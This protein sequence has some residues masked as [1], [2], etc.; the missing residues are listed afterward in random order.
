MT[1]IQQ[2]YSAD[3]SFVSLQSR[4][5]LI[6][7][8][9][10]IDD[11]TVLLGLIVAGKV[12]ADMIAPYLTVPEGDAL[13]DFDLSDT[14]AE[15]VA[16]GHVP[17]KAW[18]ELHQIWYRW[19]VP[20]GAASLYWW[21][22]FCHAMRKTDDTIEASD[23]LAQWIDAIADGDVAQRIDRQRTLIGLD[24]KSGVVGL[25]ND[26]GG[27]SC[28]LVAALRGAPLIPLTTDAD[29][30]VLEQ[31]GITVVWSDL[32]PSGPAIP[33]LHQ[34]VAGHGRRAATLQDL[35]LG[36]P[37]PVGRLRQ[38]A[39]DLW[40]SMPEDE[41]T[42]SLIHL[43]QRLAS[44]EAVRLSYGNQVYDN[45]GIAEVLASCRRVAVTE[46]SVL[47]ITVATITWCWQETGFVVQELNQ[48]EISLAALR[49]FL[50]RRIGDY[51][52]LVGGEVATGLSL[53]VLAEQFAKL[54]RLVEGSYQR[55]LYFDGGNWE[56]R[57]FLIPKIE[58]V[59]SQQGSLPETLRDY[60]R[61]R[62]GVVAD[63]G[64]STEVLK[65][66]LR[67][68]LDQDRTPSELLMAVADWAANT[69]DMWTDYAI[70]TV[71]YGVKLDRPWDI[72]ID[73]Y[74]CYTAIADGFQP[75]QAGIPLKPV[76]ICN[77]IGQRMR[78][79]ALKKAQNYALVKHMT[80]QSFLMP[81]ISVAEDA[82]QGG[83]LAAGVRH[84]CRIPTAITYQ[85]SLWKGIA[86]VRLSRANYEETARFREDELVVAARYGS[87][88][89]AIADEAYAQGCLF[90]PVYC[91]NLEDGRDV[92]SR[93]GK[94]L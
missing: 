83:H 18:D 94:A 57:E 65:C 38:Q 6:T 10:T 61:Q 67:A 21:Y 85:G 19:K 92:A 22:L 48:S 20:F 72:G 36:R 39:L 73:E 90:D 9:S 5:F 13:T 33:P 24:I 35:C 66:Y 12:P 86:D 45:T 52:A 42:Y 58:F 80:P 4:R 29:L 91:V 37:L 41:R 84:T 16:A 68:L 87:W 17:A 59:Q 79:N 64:G 27:L 1:V 89:K 8:E 32:R 34:D 74:F 76:S 75:K 11:L 40:Q 60:L 47:E 2:T 82:T 31:A 62:F 54:R 69:K 46:W 44:L 63:T 25:R 71:P 3:V 26:I 14:M 81:D 55:C 56:R 77:A 23:L 7:P 93:L 30:H 43:Q 49:V 70:F 15:I 53:P 28:L 51:L 88:A 50:E 78:Y